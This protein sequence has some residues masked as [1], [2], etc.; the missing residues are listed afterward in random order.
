MIWSRL[1]S[2]VTI[3][4]GSAFSAA[5]ARIARSRSMPVMFGMFQSVTTRSNGCARSSDSAALPSSA[6]WIRVLVKPNSTRRF[7]TMRR[8]VEKSSTTRI[9]MFLSKT[10]LRLATARS[11]MLVFPTRH[12]CAESNQGLAVDLAYPRFAH[13]QH[14]TDFLQVELFIVVQRH[15]QLLALGQSIDG[16]RQR[17]TQAFLLEQ[18][19]RTRGIR[20]SDVDRRAFVAFGRRQAKQPSTRR[21]G[22]DLVVFHGVDAKPLHHFRVFGVATRLVFDL[23]RNLRHLAQLPVDGARGPVRLAQF[24]QHGATN[25]DTRIGFEAG[26][27]SRRVISC[28]LEQSDHSGLHEV[29]RI[30]AWREPAHQ[31]IGDPAHQRRGVFYYWIRRDTGDLEIFGRAA[32]RGTPPPP[33]WDRSAKKPM[34]PC[35]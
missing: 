7:L 5:S 32:H 13:S 27:A 35:A 17:V 21:V 14:R 12:A 15:D 24:V 4:T 25:A 30:H 34:R 8:M 29:V 2:A 23:P 11:S 3:S 33:C 1:F 26:R 28:G 31:V 9:F 6:S 10:S 19:I 20:V 18:S 16:L 22:Q